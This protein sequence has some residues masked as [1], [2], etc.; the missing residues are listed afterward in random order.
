[1]K[2]YW[3]YIASVLAFFALVLNGAPIVPVVAGIA[4]SAA[5]FWLRKRNARTV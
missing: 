3:F 4:A 2:W 1:M 5:L